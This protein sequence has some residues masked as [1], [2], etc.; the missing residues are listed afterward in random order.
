[1][2]INND[3]PNITKVLTHSIV[4]LFF[5]LMI[6]RPPR[7][8]LFPYTTALPICTPAGRPTAGRGLPRGRRLDPGRARAA[9]AGALARHRHSGLRARLP[10][11]A[12]LRPRGRLEPGRDRESTRLNSRHQLISYALL[13]LKKK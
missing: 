3:S 1:M 8:P 5:F 11:V 7:S 2:G 13:F 10:G 6:R 9:A 12:P 4:I